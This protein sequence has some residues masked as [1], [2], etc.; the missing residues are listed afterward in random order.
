MDAWLARLESSRTVRVRPRIPSTTPTEKGFCASGAKLP[1]AFCLNRFVI[2]RSFL[3]RGPILRC[4]MHAAPFDRSTHRSL[5]MENEAALL[6]IFPAQI[7]TL[8]RSASERGC[9]VGERKAQ[10]TCP[11]ACSFQ[12]KR[13]GARCRRFHPISGP[14]LHMQCNMTWRSRHHNIICK[15]RRPNAHAKQAKANLVGHFLTHGLS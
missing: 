3:A 14:E 11:V 9:G 1:G 10:G 2:M 13:R 8:T 12:V 15:W 7:A 5:A 6:D 4:M